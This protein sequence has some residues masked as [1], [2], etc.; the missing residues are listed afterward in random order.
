V[1]K[2][3]FLLTLLLSMP[4][5]MALANDEPIEIIVG[6]FAPPNTPWDADWQTFK[7]NAEEQS[8]GDIDVK[9]LIRAET[10]GEPITMSNI[11]RG[12]IQFGGFTIAGAAAI[13]PELSML[14]SPFFFESQAEL[15]Y[16]MDQH[17][18]EVFRP[19]FAEKNLYLINW[20]EVGWVNMYGQKPILIPED[21]AG[22]RLRSQASEASQVFMEALDGDLMQM[23]FQD[24]IP[25]LQT[26]LV[27]GGETGVLIY[28]VTGLGHEAPHLTL[29][30]HTYDTGVIVANYD[31]IMSLPAE[32]R[33]LITNAFP[34]PAEARA[35]TRGMTN[36]LMGQIASNPEISVH[37]LTP[38]ARESWVSAT[39][40][41]YL[42]IIDQVGGQSAA[43]YDA[44]IKARAQY[45]DDD[46]GGSNE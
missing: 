17:M 32:M 19:L 2:T 15:D 23:P 39:E 13:V 29:T 43:V 42:T 45:R 11:R 4:H 20:V 9:L 16:V 36:Y 41:N 14:L 40:N 44:M 37:E 7:R 1:K 34:S 6:A 26:G 21:G 27:E 12:R 10:G 8:N 24:L 38:E 18:L 25:A 33:A 5:H 22:Y 3:I 31:W 28:A 46:E 35:S 30:Q